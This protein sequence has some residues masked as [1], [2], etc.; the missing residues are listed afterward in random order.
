MPLIFLQF[1]AIFVLTQRTIVRYTS[2]INRKQMNERKRGNEMKKY[3]IYFRIN[4]YLM[5]NDYEEI[6]GDLDSRVIAG[7]DEDDAISR[8]RKSLERYMKGTETRTYDLE[9]G[10]VEER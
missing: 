9:I 2:S 8:L 1:F 5:I 6:K 7:K 10:S 4:E 3:K